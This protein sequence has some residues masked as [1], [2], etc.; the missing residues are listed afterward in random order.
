MQCLILKLGGWG[1]GSAFSG[2]AEARGC[3]WLEEGKEEQARAQLTAR[4]LFSAIFWAPR[5]SRVCKDWLL[6]ENFSNMEMLKGETACLCAQGQLGFGVWAAKTLWTWVS[7]C[8][9]G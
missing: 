2:A 1:C 5:Q 6:R 8:L 3:V 4:L 7:R 9:C